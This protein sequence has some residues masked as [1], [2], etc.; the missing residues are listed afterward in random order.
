M[1]KT[2]IRKKITNP[3]YEN[4]K[5]HGIRLKIIARPPPSRTVRRRTR[6]SDVWVL[7]T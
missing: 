2:A 6:T 1:N 4:V 5:K 7:C 3:F